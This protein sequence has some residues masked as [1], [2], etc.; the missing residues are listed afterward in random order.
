MEED[1]I[2]GKILVLVIKSREKGS[3]GGRV[4]M[5]VNN[6]NNNNK[7]YACCMLKCLSL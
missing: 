5:E 1:R 3:T 6:N 2:Q 4:K 7:L